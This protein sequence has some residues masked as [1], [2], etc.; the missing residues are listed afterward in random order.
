VAGAGEVV[1]VR[2]GL[3]DP[4]HLQA[5]AAHVGQQPVGGRSAGAAGGGVVVQHRIDDGGAA[6]GS[7]GHDVG[8]R[9]GLWV[10]EA[11]NVGAGGHANSWAVPGAVASLIGYI[12]YFFI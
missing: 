3:Q 1:G 10:E 7:V 9:A 12:L 5:V 2:V 6:R 4:V 8:H 11:L